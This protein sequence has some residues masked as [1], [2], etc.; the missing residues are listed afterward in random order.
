MAWME[1]QPT[2]FPVQ[3]FRA[4]DRHFAIGIGENRFDDSHLH[5]ELN[6]SQCQLAGEIHL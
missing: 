2:M 6:N 4:Y 3:D 5:L 1:Q